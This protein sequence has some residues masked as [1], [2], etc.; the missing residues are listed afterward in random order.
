VLALGGSDSIIWQ[1][2]FPWRMI[3]SVRR[4]HV[5]KRI[6]VPLDGSK[7][8]E[9]ALPHAVAQA[10]LGGGTL[11]LLRAILPLTA[12]VIA[13]GAAYIDWDRIRADLEAEARAY[14]EGLRARLAA[15]GLNV[16]VD[17][18]EGAPADVIIEAEERHGIDLVVMATH[19]RSGLGRWVIGSV[20][21][22]VVRAGK[23]PVL[24]IRPRELPDDAAG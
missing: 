9:V 11:V 12:A 8:A 21:D 7:L 23:A 4:I 13:E 22:R 19:G 17:Y 3:A 1:A 24:L 18:R 5:Y 6:L 20:A 2:L 10:K 14:L 15:E 16:V